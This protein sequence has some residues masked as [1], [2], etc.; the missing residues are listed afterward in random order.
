[1]C[2]NTK[3]LKKNTISPICC[4]FL[5]LLGQRKDDTKKV[6]ATLPT[7]RVRYRD[8]NIDITTSEIR[9]V[10]IEKFLFIHKCCKTVFPKIIVT[11]A[12]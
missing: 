8:R 7:L 5:P 3:K 10:T 2:K 6:I 4:F 9:N 11:F 12:L 1:M